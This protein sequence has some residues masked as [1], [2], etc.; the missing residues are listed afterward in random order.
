MNQ[1]IEYWKKYNEYANMLSDALGRTKNVV[2]EFAEYL[3]HQYYGGELQSIS[4]VSADIKTYDGKLYQVKSRKTN[5]SKTTQLN[6]IRS[7]NFDFLVVILFDE[8]GNLIKALEIPQ[9]IAKEYGK[10]NNHQNGWVVTTTKQ[11]LC[12]PRNKD[13]T[14]SLRK[15]F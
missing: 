15:L 9:E 14:D 1:I 6:G 10:R 12:D 11:F 8:S 2:G 3:A 4:G 5:G 13:L 7:W